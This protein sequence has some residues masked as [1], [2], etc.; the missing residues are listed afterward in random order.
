MRYRMGLQDGV[1]FLMV[2]EMVGSRILEAEQRDCCL[3]SLGVFYT[4]N[5]RHFHSEMS[6]V[7]VSMYYNDGD[8]FF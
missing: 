4:L 6:P 8:M 2:L 3:L 5:D 1:R 7:L